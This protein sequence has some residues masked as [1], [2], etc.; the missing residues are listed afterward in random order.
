MVCAGLPP[1]EMSWRLLAPRLGDAEA[2]LPREQRG[3]SQRAQLK[4]S[5]W[6]MRPGRHP[7]P[8]AAVRPGAALD[9][10][11]VSA[12]LVEHGRRLLVPVASL[13]SRQ[14]RRC[15]CIAV[16]I[17]CPGVSGVAVIW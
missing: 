6:V 15:Y 8:R 12:F 17:L 4:N 7:Q 9:A 14:P 1:A 3:E 10:A 13:L 11:I 5:G 2:S 16:Y